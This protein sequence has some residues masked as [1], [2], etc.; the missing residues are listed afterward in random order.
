MVFG[1]GFSSQ[2]GK[3]TTDESSNYSGNY[4]RQPTAPAPWLQNYYGMLNQYGYGTATPVA[5]NPPQAAPQNVPQQN[6][7][8][9]SAPAQNIGGVNYGQG[10]YTPY[11]D[12][13]PFALAQQIPSE[14]G[15]MPL[16]SGGG[17]NPQMGYA[18]SGG[19][20][21]GTAVPP[22]TPNPAGNQGYTPDQAVGAGFINQNLANNPTQ[23]YID[24]A[25]NAG[26][27]VAVG[28]DNLAGDLANLN[29]N[30]WNQYADRGSYTIGQLE[31]QYPEMYGAVDPVTA[32]QIQARQ[33]SEFMGDYLNPY[34]SDVVDASLADY[35]FGTNRALAEMQGRRDAGSA[36]GSRANLSDA[37]FNADAAR[38]RGSLAAGLR[39]Q[40][41]NTALGAGMQDANRF[42]SAD[43]TNAAN[44]LNAA[45][46]NNAQDMSRKMFDVNAAYQGDQQRMQAL[47]NMQNNML[48][49]GNFG[50]SAADLMNNNAN[51][52]MLQ[53]QL[54]TGNANLLFNMGGAQFSNPYDLLALGVNLFGEQGSESGQSSGTRT[55]KTKGSGFSASGSFDFGGFGGS[56]KG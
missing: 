7:S 3:S 10:G 45:Q 26:G 18:N 47:N 21:D 55:T 53:N 39:S 54:Q 23:P 31:S 14:Y 4:S 25:I 28:L 20:Q 56:G 13:T 15:S 11:G 1:I 27:N 43:T 46:F 41:F 36:F 50:L 37:V 30:Y 19:R 34:L 33:G 44:L 32:Q 12:V 52:A 40:G 38:G 49:Q 17:Q 35:D 51:L 29:S 5:Q 9:W 48:M 42:L 8:P 24:E 22:G 16:Y 2:K 6:P